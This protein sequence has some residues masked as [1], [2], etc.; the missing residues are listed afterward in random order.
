[1]Y[2]ASRTLEVWVRSSELYQLIV[3]KGVLGA[4]QFTSKK[5]YVK[6]AL[7][8]MIKA[9]CCILTLQTS[10]RTTSTLGSRSVHKGESSV[11]I[12]LV[13]PYA[14]YTILSIAVQTLI[15]SKARL[16]IAA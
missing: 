11:H 15:H 8:M 7:S 14:D 3:D 12:R 9:Y 13:V 1:M 4:N 16:H 5:V 6:C 2:D 10:H